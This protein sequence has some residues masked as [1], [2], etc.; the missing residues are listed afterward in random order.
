MVSSTL[1]LNYSQIG[2]LITRLKPKIEITDLRFALFNLQSLFSMATPN[3]ASELR[4]HVFPQVPSK[5]NVKSPKFEENSAKWK[6]II[7]KYEEA[8]VEA[9]REGKSAKALEK[10]TTRHILGK[11]SSGRKDQFVDI[12]QHEIEL[13]FCEIR[14]LLS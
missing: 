4:Q 14:I 10:H 7:Q 1:G 11:F 6:H 3:F 8:S 2:C 13:P 9:S 5:I 12:A